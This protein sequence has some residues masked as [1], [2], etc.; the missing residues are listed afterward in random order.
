VL[1][2]F[3][4]EEKEA[5]LHLRELGGWPLQDVIEA[6]VACDKDENTAADLLFSSFSDR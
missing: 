2:R 6:F 5:I 3:P 1:A 4:T